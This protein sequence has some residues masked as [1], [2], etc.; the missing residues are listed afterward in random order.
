M[1][2]EEKV[3]Q[4]GSMPVLELLEDGKFS[5]EK[6]GKLLKNGIGLITRVA[7]SRAGRSK[8]TRPPRSPTTSKGSSSKR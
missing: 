2:I 8:R 1:T 3:S 7:G 5:A 6:A 4:L